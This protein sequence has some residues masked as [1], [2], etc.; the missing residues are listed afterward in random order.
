[1]KEMLPYLRLIPKPA[2]DAF[3]TLGGHTGNVDKEQTL[4]YLASLDA[5]TLNSIIDGLRSRNINK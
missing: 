3:N 2:S 4:A 1:M 5:D